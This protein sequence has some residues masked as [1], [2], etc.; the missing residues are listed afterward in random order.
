MNQGLWEAAQIITMDA[1]TNAHNVQFS[2]L[3]TVTTETGCQNV[4][5]V[6]LFLKASLKL[7]LVQNMGFPLDSMSPEEHMPTCS[8]QVQIQT[9]QSLFYKDLY[10]LGPGTSLFML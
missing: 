9:V 4:L 10:G 8:S 5:H 1:T 7:Q 6:D 2:K 3:R